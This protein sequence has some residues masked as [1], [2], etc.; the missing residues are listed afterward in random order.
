MKD[1]P[2]ISIH[3]S[4]GQPFDIMQSFSHFVSNYGMMADSYSFGCT[5]KYMLT[6]VQPNE[7]IDE[8]IAFQNNPI[9]KL[10]TWISQQSCQSKNKPPSSSSEREKRYRP[11]RKLPKEVVRLIQGLTHPKVSRRTSIRA[12]RRFFWIDDIL[13]EDSP[14]MMPQ[15]IDYLKCALS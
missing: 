15:K 3:I 9:T 13:G 11:M 6:G 12:A 14:E 7:N 4:S 2:N 1:D 10:C 5:L 8:V